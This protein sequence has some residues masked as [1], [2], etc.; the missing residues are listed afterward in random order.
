MGKII[1]AFLLAVFTVSVHAAV[2]LTSAQDKAV[3][4]YIAKE[5]KERTANREEVEV[6][7]TIV[8]DLNGDGK[9]EVVLGVSFLGGTWWSNGLV[10]LS[11]KGKGYQVVA[12]EGLLGSVQSIDVKN[13]L[14]HVNSLQAAPN[15]PRCCP[16]IKETTIY[17]W[18]GTKLLDV[19]GKKTVTSPKQSVPA[20]TSNIN[21]EWKLTTIRGVKLASVKQNG[22]GIQELTVL[23]E[24]RLPKLAVRLNVPQSDPLRL[25]I[26]IGQMIYP[27]L[28]TQKSNATGYRVFNLSPSALPKGLLTGHQSAQVKINGIAYS[29]LSLRH[30]A[31][32]SKQALSGC[33]RY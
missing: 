6:N 32:T 4:A 13:S 28:T 23:C 1:Y 15:D 5:Q 20:I 3:K 2:A 21:S 31:A 26:Q 18:N 14:I 22:K 7:N 11:D 19:T 29:A 33:Y 8:T 30:A 12:E 9:A 24:D 27:F 25:E 17:Q 16:S 10:I